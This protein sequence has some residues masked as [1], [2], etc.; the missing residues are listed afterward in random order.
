M[1]RDYIA[2]VDELAVEAD[3]VEPFH[4]GRGDTD[5]LHHHIRAAPVREVFHALHAGLGSLELV[6]VGYR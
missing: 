5:D 6:H 1:L 3:H 2:D 4:G